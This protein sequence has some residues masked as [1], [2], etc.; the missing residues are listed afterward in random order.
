[1]TSL[2]WNMMQIGR[3]FKPY[4]ALS[5]ILE[6]HSCMTQEVYDVHAPIAIHDTVL[7]FTK[8]FIPFHKIPP[9]EV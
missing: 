1:M 5:Y 7:P 8:H 9:T 2:G 4:I 3:S 6:S